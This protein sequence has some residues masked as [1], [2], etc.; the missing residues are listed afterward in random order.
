M[1]VIN[2]WWCG[3]S[4]VL[5]CGMVFWSKPCFRDTVNTCHHI[6]VHAVLRDWW[7]CCNCVLIFDVII[8][9]YD[10]LYF[11]LCNFLCCHFGC[12]LLCSLPVLFLMSLLIMQRPLFVNVSISIM[13]LF[14]LS[15]LQLVCSQSLTNFATL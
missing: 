11:F 4:F 5:F 7:L 12:S 10:S 2:L 3:R 6:I 14:L 1:L 8:F 9:I 15:I 13:G